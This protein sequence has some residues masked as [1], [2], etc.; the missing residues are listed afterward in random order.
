MSLPAE[1]EVRT[2]GRLHGKMSGS[3]AGE[4][5]P[6]DESQCFNTIHACQ[7]SQFA[8]LISMIGKRLKGV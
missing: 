4:V 7:L 2:V 1:T 3:R 5:H 8:A 6:S